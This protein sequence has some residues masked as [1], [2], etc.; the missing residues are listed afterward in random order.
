MSDVRHV[1]SGRDEYYVLKP[2]NYDN[3]ILLDETD[4]MFKRRNSI[5]G[6]FV[7]SD[8]RID[9]E[10]RDFEKTRAC[11]TK[12]CSPWIV[13]DED[14][15]LKKY[16]E[17]IIKKAKSN[18]KKIEEKKEKRE[19]RKRRERRY[20]NE[21]SDYVLRRER[22]YDERPRKRTKKK[23][24]VLL[25]EYDIIDEEKERMMERQ[26][27]EKIRQRKEQDIQ[28]EREQSEE[29]AEYL[30]EYEEKKDKRKRRSKNKESSDDGLIPT[31]ILGSI[32]GV[33]AVIFSMK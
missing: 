20:L 25:S 28:L 26:K 3:V 29:R 21:D 12:D 10:H 2:S 19:R 8:K 30:K 24:R 11:S 13:V 14:N 15:Q 31:V 4:N 17:R 32:L 18:L 7:S 16:L 5:Y 22:S 33:F 9:E 23:R 27:R 1:N 6:K